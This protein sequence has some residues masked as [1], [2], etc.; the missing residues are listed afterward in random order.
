MHHRGVCNYIHWGIRHYGADAGNGAP[1]FSS[2]AVDLTITNLLPLFAGHPV[3]FLAE[4]SPVEAL[5]EAL[6]AGPEFG[7]I[8]IT[9]IH[10]ALLTPMLTAEQAARAAKTL[11]IGA[12]FLPAEPTVWWQDNVP[13]VRLMNEYGP[14]E[15]VVGCSA[16]TLPNGVH[17]YGAVPVGGPID[18]ITFYVL[19]SRM[20]PVPVGL[21]GELYIGGV[22]V[23]RGYLGRP[24]LSAEKFVPDAFAGVGARM[25]R[26]G[27]RARW[28]AD[29]NLMILGRTDAQVKIRGYRV[30]LGE[31]EA[32]LRRHP[33]VSGA[34]VVV[35]EDQPGDR[36]LVGYV[37]GE[38]SNEALRD[39]LRQALPEYMV[40][41]AFVRLDTLPQTA[42]GKVDPRTL[43]APEFRSAAERYVAPRTAVEEL[44]AGVW[45]EVLQVERV[46]A[47]DGFFELGGHSLTA[48]Q[49]ITRVQ[50]AFGID[51]PI[52]ALFAN[53]TLETLAAEIERIVYE[54]VLGMS[55]D[56]AE[57]LADLNLIAG[58]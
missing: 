52:R 46:G 15:T 43:P 28:Q 19:D 17:R 26:T 41:A 6:R 32:V 45:A 40:P 20:Q 33:D 7:M 30:E 8:K 27:D 51:L 36:R 29:G 47:E 35:R 56:D 13:G 37:V 54:D 4:E 3:R 31:I 16:Y 58:D 11:V 22:G 14:T 44:L 23:A 50:A 25:Y 38:A 2:M 55:E 9:P 53:P 21:P 18:N 5:A 1:V 39:H 49:L 10:L 57:Q 24:S 34:L 12:D 42:T 48:M